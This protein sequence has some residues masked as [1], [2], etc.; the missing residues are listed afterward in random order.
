MTNAI[1]SVGIDN[2]PEGQCNILLDNKY[3]TLQSSVLLSNNYNI[4]SSGTCGKKQI[5]YPSNKM[6]LTN[7]Y[8]CDKSKVMYDRVNIFFVYSVGRK[9]GC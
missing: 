4:S 2:D 1:I 6:Y 8:D 5:G 9:Q 7:K 3:T